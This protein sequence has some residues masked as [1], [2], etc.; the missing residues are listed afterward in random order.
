MP[1]LDEQVNRVMFSIY[2]SLWEAK[3]LCSH[4]KSAT[5]GFL[6]LDNLNCLLLYMNTNLDQNG[7]R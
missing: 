2:Y 5:S 4:V 1:L 6:Q 7:N 3:G